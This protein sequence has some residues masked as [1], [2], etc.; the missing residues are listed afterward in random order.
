M[1]SPSKL[2]ERENARLF[3]LRPTFGLTVPEGIVGEGSGVDL[4]STCRT[5]I[6]QN[7]TDHCVQ[8]GPTSFNNS[9]VRWW[10]HWCWGASRPTHVPAYHELRWGFNIAAVAE[11]AVPEAQDT[12]GILVVSKAYLSPASMKPASP[13][14]LIHPAT[15]MSPA[16]KWKKS[17]ARM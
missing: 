4:K 3:R 6:H 11:L 17:P 1:S 12:S 14:A 16:S 8:G 7:E 15:L 2:C 10:R 9:E 13:Q 5:K